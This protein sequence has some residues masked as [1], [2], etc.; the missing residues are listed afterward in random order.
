MCVRHLD[1]VTVLLHC[2]QC[3]GNL[4]LPPPAAL[5]RAQRA[6]SGS[7][8]RWSSAVWQ[9]PWVGAAR[10]GTAREAWVRVVLPPRQVAGVAQSMWIW[11]NTHRGPRG[12][13]QS[14]PLFWHFSGQDPPSI[15]FLEAKDVENGVAQGLELS[16]CSALPAVWP[17]ASSLT[18]LCLSFFPGSTSGKGTIY[19][20][21][22]RKRH[23]FHPWVGKIPWRRAWQPTPV[24][25]P[26]ESHGQRSLVGY[27]P[28]GCKESDMNEVTSHACTP[29]LPV[30]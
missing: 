11:E 9:L 17:W 15:P 30:L 1:H 26:G 22:K 28:W 24:F 3:I 4:S 29:Q 25:L 12:Q 10:G 8:G 18:S 20:C 27:S 21:R 5:D 16:L 19:Q 14:G 13:E 2:V 6:R 23:R 7:A